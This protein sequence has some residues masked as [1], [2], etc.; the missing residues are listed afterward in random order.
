MYSADLRK[1]YDL[2]SDEWKYDIMPEIFEG[3]NIADFIDPDIDARLAELERE[4]EALEAEH[5][6]LLDAQVGGWVSICVSSNASKQASKQA[7]WY[8]AMVWLCE[9]VMGP[10]IQTLMLRWQS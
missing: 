5:Q 6:Q 4:E 10:S 9:V 7:G 3:H 8:V 2:K 1:H